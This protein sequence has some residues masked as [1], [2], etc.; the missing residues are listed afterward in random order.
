MSGANQPSSS[1]LRAR[2]RAIVACAH[3]RAQ[4]LAE[5]GTVHRFFRGV[6]FVVLLLVLPFALLLALFVLASVGQ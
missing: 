6:P 3:P 5:L 4:H 2:Y 1:P